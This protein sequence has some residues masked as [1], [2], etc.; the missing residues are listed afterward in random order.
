MC[1]CFAF[2]ITCV[3]ATQEGYGPFGLAD[4]AFADMQREPVVTSQQV[5]FVRA[6]NVSS[7]GVTSDRTRTDGSTIVGKAEAI[8]LQEVCAP[9]CV[10][11][12]PHTPRAP[13]PPQVSHFPPFSH[14][15]Y[16]LLFVFGEAVARCLA[17]PSVCWAEALPC[18]FDCLCAPLCQEHGDNPAF[19]AITRTDFQ[20]KKKIEL[21]VPSFRGQLVKEVRANRRMHKGRSRVPPP[22]NVPGRCKGRI[23]VVLP[24]HCRFVGFDFPLLGLFRE[25]IQ[26]WCLRCVTG[27]VGFR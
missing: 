1:G 9:L 3:C 14:T 23:L 19:G 13:P 5:E 6:S 15:N 8:A 22:T 7:A 25:F 2:S 27:S 12:A 17:E 20:R 16:W 21:A 4:Q 10:R 18:K 24:R 26:L 11:P